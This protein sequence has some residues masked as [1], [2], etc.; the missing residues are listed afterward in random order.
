MADAD[1]QGEA[2][3][4]VVEE[5]PAEKK[6]ENLVAADVEPD[7]SKEGWIIFVTGVHEEAQEEDVR[8][9]FYVAPLCCSQSSFFSF[10]FFSFLLG[11]MLTVLHSA[12]GFSPGR[13]GICFQI[14]GR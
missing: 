9:C 8:L 2:A 1:V 6:V 13:C 4:A 12:D 3:A 5:A 14:M 7:H 11:G 10:L